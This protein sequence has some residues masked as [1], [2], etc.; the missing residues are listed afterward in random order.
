MWP[1]VR[2]GEGPRSG[3]VSIARTGELGEGGGV[4][5]TVLIA[6]EVGSGKSERRR[7][8]V[9]ANIGTVSKE[10][11]KRRE[12]VDPGVCANTASCRSQGFLLRVLFPSREGKC[13]AVISSEAAKYK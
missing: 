8:R 9:V 6:Q 11:L 2:G 13:V 10:L 3:R 12:G 5:I 7:E 4:D 1:R